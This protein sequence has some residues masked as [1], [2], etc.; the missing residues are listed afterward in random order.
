MFDITREE[1]SG[2]IESC[3]QKDDQ[4]VWAESTLQYVP[5][6]LFATGTCKSPEHL[7]CTQFNH[8]GLYTIS[9][10][11]Y[12]LCSG[13][14]V[15]I[16]GVLSVLVRKRHLCSSTILVC[17][18]RAGRQRQHCH[19]S[20]DRSVSQQWEKPLCQLSG[21]ARFTLS[22][23]QIR[24]ESKWKALLLLTSLSPVYLI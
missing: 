21:T 12:Y 8:H 13:P 23:E 2:W 18:H 17:P 11:W 6:F 19:V 22:A 20:A 5:S 9:S 1:F 24:S 16:H 4:M 3:L 10:D 14:S 15:C 7:S